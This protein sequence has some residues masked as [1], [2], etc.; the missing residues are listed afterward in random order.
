MTRAAFRI[1]LALCALGGLTSAAA[2]HEV[3]PGY[4]ELRELG[5]DRFA[6][7]W[8]I[9]ARGDLRFGIRAVL[10]ERCARV[11]E[12]VE[13]WTGDAYV[14]R[15]TLHCPDGLDGEPIAIAGL[16]ATV[17]DVLVR[18]ARADGSAQVVRLTPAAPSFTVEPAPGLLGVARTYLALGIEH[19]LLGVDHLAFVLALLLLVDSRRSLVHSRRSL[20]QSARRLVATV[21]AFTVAHSLTLAAATLGLVHVPSAPVEVVI[22]L[23][24]VF[25]AAEIAR[26]LGHAGATGR[27]GLTAR[28]PW[29][30]A[31]AFGLLHGFGFAG[32]LAEVGLPPQAIPVALLCFNLGVE[33]GQLAFV[34]VALAAAA[35]LRH[36]P[37]AWPAWC[38]LVPPYAIGSLAAYWTLARLVQP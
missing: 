34:A 11:G 12:P 23:S 33:L 26:G 8:K 17:I 7:L 37:V 25:V 28:R 15:A 24:I 2:A 16:S 9:P 20:V 4:L 21:T 5:S 22:A 30:V 18:V 32:A 3:R 27:P 1:A 6:L 29:L 35:L 38:R 31:F 14:E 13:T 36:A 10:P 19:I